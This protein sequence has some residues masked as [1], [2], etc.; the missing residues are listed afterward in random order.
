MAQTIKRD[1]DADVVGSA[2][3]IHSCLSRGGT[4]S[5]G[6]QLSEGSGTDPMIQKK[7]D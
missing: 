4:A 5:F 6:G 3:T 7:R 2:R 1:A